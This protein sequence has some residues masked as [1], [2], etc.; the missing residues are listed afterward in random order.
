[1]P[2]PSRT[3]T[4]LLALL[5]AVALPAHAE[6]PFDLQAGQVDYDLESN[7]I[8]ATGGVLVSGNE[9]KL[10]ADTIT[11]DTAADTI[12]AEGHVLYTDAVGTTLKVNRLELTGN[13]KGGTAQALRLAVP[14]LGEIM[15]ASSATRRDDNTYVLKDVDYS[16]CTECIGDSKPWT[17]H[18]DRVVYKPDDGEMEYNNAWMDVYGVPV[19]YL[20]YFQHPIGPRKPKTGMLFPQ[21]GHSTVY[22]DEIRLAGYTFDADANADYTLR[23]RLM[24]SKGAQLIGQRRQ[25]TSH[26]QSEINASYLNDTDTGKVRSH[27]NLLGSYTFNPGTR[28][29]LNG[30]I[31]SDD[32]YLNDFF[33][34]NDPYLASTAYAEHN[35]ANRYLSL[36]ATRFQD[37]DPT[38]APAGTAQVLPHLLYEELIPL[39]GGTQ[40][41]LG[42][43]LLALHRGTGTQYRRAVTQ[44]NLAHPMQL[45][46]GS[47]LTLGG[48]MRFDVYNVDSSTNDGTALRALPEATFNWEKPYISEGGFH[49]IT[50]RVM[51]ALSF[52]GN[53]PTGIPNE[54]S[55]AYEL[56]YANLFEPSR[57]A[58][59][60]RVETGPRLVYGVDNHWGGANQTRWQLFLGQSLRKYDD[61]NLPQS[62]GA[63][64]PVSDFVGFA[65][66]SPADWLT[67]NSRF[68]LD[69][70]TFDIRRMDNSL[71]LGHYGDEN[72]W[73][74]GTYS[75]LDNDTESLTTEGNLPLNERLRFTA[76][77]R[78]D[79]R[80]NNTL[81]AE[82]GLIYRRDC[83]EIGFKVR[84]RGFVNGDIRPSTDYLLNIQLLTLGSETD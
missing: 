19:A 18:A 22:G 51:G 40:L 47:K 21:F 79:L 64:T 63:A 56:D 59:L 41:T 32:T 49:T 17:I 60:D 10:N 1:M 61:N 37:L 6:M 67:F 27:L 28:V 5:L 11:Y 7:T 84:R 57:F 52:R 13:L 81:Q 8:H 44:A 62:G 82:G 2:H 46:D 71:Q 39:S 75:F 29:G 23:T 69:N 55:V 78:H 3:F 50:P 34:R 58:G 54:D 74:R 48:R 33:E 25:V 15:S 73:L 12:L 66:G 20:P 83:Y 42:A 24:S 76:A 16:P 53:N 35:T 80:N 72:A 68:R 70:A 31:S 38:R 65:Q 4:V 36:S 14:Q 26:T 43:D 77:S 30:E 9:G 45:A